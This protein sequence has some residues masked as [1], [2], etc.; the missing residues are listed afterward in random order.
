[1]SSASVLKICPQPRPRP[2]RFVLGLEDLSSASKICPRLTSLLSNASY[3]DRLSILGLRSLQL[4]RLYQDLIYTYK[5]IFGLVDLD[6]PKFFLVSPNETTR[7]HVNKFFVRQSRVDVRKYFFGNRAV[8]IWN[9]LPATVEDFAKF[10]SI[11]KRKFK[12]FIERVNLS[13]YV[14]F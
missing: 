10:A 3:S 9:S 8:K 7:G 2:Q 4:R 11:R 1:M 14:N 13:Q 6:C 5:I 12:S